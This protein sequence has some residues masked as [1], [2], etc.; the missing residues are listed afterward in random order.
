MDKEVKQAI[1]VAVIEA[2]NAGRIFTSIDIA[3]DVKRGGTWVR[4]R[5]VAEFLRSYI[6]PYYS[7]YRMDLIN[8]EVDG[9]IVQAYCYRPKS[10]PTSDY[11]ARDQTAV[12]W[13]EYLVHRCDNI[14]IE[15]EK[16]IGELEELTQ[17]LLDTSWQVG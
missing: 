10:T 6:D 12:T 7:N 3:N 13:D 17:K 8:V 1:K 9:D 5:F 11:D 15:M 16:K 2:T 4:N 14:K